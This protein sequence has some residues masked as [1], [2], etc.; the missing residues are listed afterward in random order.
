MKKQLRLTHIILILILL[1]ALF[2]RVYRLGISSSF[3]GDEVTTITSSKENLTELLKLESWTPLQA[4]WM[5]FGAQVL[6][7]GYSE[8]SI[9]LLSGIVSLVA[10]YVVYKLGKL[11]FD[12][13]VGLL[14]VFMLVFSVY[15]IYYS[16]SARYYSMIVLLSSVAF[17]CLYWALVSNQKKAWFFY[18]LF[19]ILS[20]YDHLSALWMFFGE[21]IF[22]LGY[23]TIPW[24]RNAWSRWYKLSFLL[25]KKS[26]SL[27]WNFV[28]Q[29]TTSKFFWF[30]ISFAFILLAYVPVWF[31]ML[32]EVFLGDSIFRISSL[33]SEHMAPRE[34]RTGQLQSM[35]G[36]GWRGPLLVVEQLTGWITPLHIILLI[37]F[38]LGVIYCILKR[39]WTQLLF[40]LTI[41]ITPFILSIFIRSYSMVLDGRYLISLLP[42]Y[43][44]MG[45]RGIMGLGQSIGVVA[46]SRRNIGGY[47]QFGTA[48]IFVIVISGLNLTRI[49]LTF[50]NTGQNWRAVSQF[51]AQNATPDELIVVD[52]R[53][54]NYQ[55]LQFYL[56]GFNVVQK[57]P[58]ISY[59]T[60]YKQ[61]NGF[62]LVYEPGWDLYTGLRYWTDING[63]VSI[64]FASGWYPDIDQYRELAPAQSW[65]LYVV[66]ASHENISSNR[67]LELHNTWLAE[68]EANNP[69]N[70]RWH[71]TMAEAYQRINECGNAINEYNQ[72]LTEGYVNHQLASYIY[73]ARGVCWSKLGGKEEL[74]IADWQMAISHAYWSKTPFQRLYAYFILLGRFDEAQELCQT[75]LHANPKKG[76]PL[77]LQGDFYRMQRLTEQAIST[78]FQAI[79]LDP[80]EQTS[81]Q[82]LAEVYMDAGNYDQVVSLYQNLILHNP[83][84]GWPHFQLGQFYNGMGKV[85]E[86][87]VEYQ[88]TVA[89]Q[90]ELTPAVSDFLHITK[91]DLASYINLVHAYSDQGEVLLWR[92]NDWI[93]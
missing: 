55:A 60:Y 8:T 38:T 2:F 9:Y 85:T 29:I 42:L 71:L 39:Q 90:P 1:A 5:K 25:K 73:D 31:P 22:V 82:H 6:G 35:L 33:S 64:V 17:F 37:L 49:P 61:E 7:M 78:Y 89:L 93:T 4:L 47:I 53:A 23:L 12:D 86:A 75:A 28:R 32:K 10:V 80:A 77:V 74:A 18:A 67:A 21:G 36:G 52:G 41:L 45:S 11:L 59:D 51:L 66:Y 62:W 72:A 54:S 20:L 79:D 16:R 30:T 48:I 26:W 27:S 69:G 15:D 91:W 44:I 3:T 50:R 76:W 34:V 24:M 58:K 83:Y 84:F 70:V 63:A 57:D 14:S 43:Y 88:K 87:L 65:D 46:G 56:L 40:I 13:R 68:A 81:Y 19:R 92:D